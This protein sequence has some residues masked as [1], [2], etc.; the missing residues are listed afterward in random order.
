MGLG[1]VIATPDD[2]PLLL[3]FPRAQSLKL[4]SSE[5]ALKELGL[6]EH[7]LRFT[8]RVQL[9][10][11]HSDS[12]T[13]HRIY[14]H[15]KRWEWHTRKRNGTG[16]PATNNSNNYFLFLH[17]PLSLPSSILEQ[18]TLCAI[19]VVIL[20]PWYFIYLNLF[21][22]LVMTC[23]T[24][25]SDFCKLFLLHLVTGNVSVMTLVSAF[26]CFSVLKGYTIQHLPD[27]TVIVE[28]IVI[29]VSSSA[30]D[31]NTKI[32]LLSWS[33]QVKHFHCL[34]TSD[35]FYSGF[36]SNWSLTWST[37]LFWVNLSYRFSLVQ[38]PY[39]PNHK[40]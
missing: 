35:L 4:V 14:T 13:L 7:Q 10:D 19:S 20:E 36:Y 28:S 31:P 22:L 26:L 27:G 3:F 15:L 6:N 11:P 2:F 29:K 8:C 30:E 33:Y 16:P 34:C 39:L 25:V 17:H 12:D 37:H 18:D 24:Y 5:Q 23:L 32:L 40:W 21:H 1:G 9:Q 38:V